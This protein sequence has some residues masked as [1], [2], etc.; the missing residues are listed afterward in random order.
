MSVAQTSRLVLEKFS[1]ADTPFIIELLN[2]PGWLRFIGDR[3]VHD[4]DAAIQYLQN[5]PLK[6]YLDHG[7]G[8]WKVSLSATGAP[9]GMCGLL[10]RPE[11]EHPDIGFAFLPQYA[12]KGFAFEAASE[13]LKLARGKYHIATL[14]A[15]VQPDNSR[16]IA[17][18]RKHNFHFV[19]TITAQPKHEKLELYSHQ[20]SSPVLTSAGPDS[21]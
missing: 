19:R 2:T 15:I 7:F 13:V 6:S 12:G 9:I 11:L 3:N 10:K 14:F 20:L 5:G 17:L 1:D 18:L 16:S 21:Q 8:L 4:T